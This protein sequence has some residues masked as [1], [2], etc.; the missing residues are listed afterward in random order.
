[1]ENKGILP[2]IQ[3][4]WNHILNVEGMLVLI[5]VC[6]KLSLNAQD[7]ELTNISLFLSRNQKTGHPS[8]SC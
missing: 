3:P 7:L 1:M 8:P 2:P 5:Q 6:F 4:M